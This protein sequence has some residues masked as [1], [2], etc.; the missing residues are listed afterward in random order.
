MQKDIKTVFFKI[1]DPSDGQKELEL[2]GK[3]I[4]EGGLVAF[5]TETVYGLGGQEPPTPLSTP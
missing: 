4:R 2:A 5:P 3:M 1:N